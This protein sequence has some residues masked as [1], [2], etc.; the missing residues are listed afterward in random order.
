MQTEQ[1][2]IDQIIRIKSSRQF[3]LYI[4]FIQFP[5]YRNIEVNSQI[6]FDFP[7]TIFIGQ[8]GCGKSSCLHALFGAPRNHTPYSFW[9][10]TQ[11]D[12]IQYYDD[13]R[14]RHSFWYKFYDENNVIRE[15]VKARIRRNN[16]P[17]YWETS[18][19]LAWAGMRRRNDQRRDQPITKPVVYIDFRAELSAF[20]KFF[21]F[22]NT[23]NLESR[24]KQEFIRRK[25]GTLRKLLSEEIR[26]VNTR[27]GPANSPIHHLTEQE[28]KWV[29]FILGREYMSG[30]YL[31]HRLY[32]NDGYSVVFRTSFGNY[33]EAFAGSGEVAVVRLV[34]KVLSAQEYSLILLDEPEVSLHPGAQN[35]LKLFLLEQIK[36]KKHQVVLTSHSPSIVHGL[37]KE[38]IKV[39]H[40]NPG[41][42][43]F[44]IKENLTP[45]EAFYHIEFPIEN[46]KNIIVEDVLAKEIISGV[47]GKM[48]EESQNLFNVKFNPGGESVIKKEF[49]T[50]YCREAN[51][52]DFIFF[53]GDQK[54]LEVPYDWR[55]FTAA[56]LSVNNLK[57]KLR[58]QTGEEIK[59]SVD[60]GQ[61]G[62]SSE[63]QKE[64]LKLYMDYY[65]SNVFYLPEQIP[66]EIIWNDQFAELLITGIIP[67]EKLRREKL[68]SL[69]G[70]QNKKQKFSFLSQIVLGENSAEEIASIHKQFIQR[71]LN[72]E[73]EHFLAIKNHIQA[74]INR[75]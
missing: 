45:E 13:Q 19:P 32:R 30:E 27:S 57:S 53:D 60:G 9:F 65:Q 39:F 31:E 44:L 14:R 41:N 43:R 6:S 24:N 72:T 58:E 18:R 26:V 22:G 62:G 63:Q 11:V 33:T 5:F 29:S 38:A 56:E 12:P 46:R 49:I 28:L 61:N 34:M 69:T 16:D 74:I 15:V 66:E 68:H 10:D 20:D 21:Y 4:D 71:W 25:S 37:P 23:D 17:N 64:L 47:L 48:G 35:R 1:E 54:K 52:K 67:E 75:G 8:N 70:I 55:T 73:N 59:F 36:I 42:G 51:K 3:R 7:L 50:V 40:Q 2:L